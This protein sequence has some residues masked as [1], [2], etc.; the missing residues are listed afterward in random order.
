[1]RRPGWVAALPAALLLAGCGPD[2]EAVVRVYANGTCHLH[3][4]GAGSTQLAVKPLPQGGVRCEVV[5]ELPEHVQ[6]RMSAEDA[7]GR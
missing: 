7:L 4:V 1:M 5:W 2:L 6:A 3:S